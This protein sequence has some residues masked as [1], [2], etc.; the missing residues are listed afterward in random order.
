M[1]RRWIVDIVC[2]WGV[3]VGYMFVTAVWYSGWLVVVWE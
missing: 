3:D 2:T 1:S